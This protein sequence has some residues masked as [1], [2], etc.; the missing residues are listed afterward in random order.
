M[1]SEIE[2]TEDIEDKQ[3][4]G[5]PLKYKTVDELGLAIQ[6]YFDKCDP[7][8]SKHMVANGINPNGE[9]M[10]ETRQVIT[11]QQ[12]YTMSGLARALGIDR[13]TLLRYSKKEEFHG[14]VAMARQ[15]CHEYA[16]S[17]LF[18]RSASG[19]QFSLKN[20]FGWVDKT[21]VDNTHSGEVIFTNSVPR[22]DK[23][24]NEN[25]QST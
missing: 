5:R 18:G 16:E 19:A 12:P 4:V 25:D 8:V 17:Q 9:T 15:R 20:N 22:P 6:N 21:E 13:D 11:E 2:K 1:A 10:F 24:N 14:T 3:P 7:H 23:Q